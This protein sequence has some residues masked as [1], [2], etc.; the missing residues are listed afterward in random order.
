[1]IVCV[2]LPRFELAVAAGGLQSLVGRPVALAPDPSAP[3]GRA[4]IGEV[5]GAA[6]A[7]GLRPG[8]ALGEALTRCPE[9]ELVAGDPVGV[10]R[11]LGAGPPGT[12][13][14]RRS[15]RV[16]AAGTGLLRRPR[17]PRALRRIRGARDRGRPPGARHTRPP[18]RRAD[19]LLRAGRRTGDPAPPDDDH[20]RGR[21]RPSAQPPR[22][23]AP[24]P[25]N[26]RSPR[27]DARA[28]GDRHAR[29]AR[30]DAPSRADR[31]FRSG[32]RRGP[33]AGLRR[34]RPSDPP[35]AGRAAGRVARA[36]RVGFGSGARARPRRP[37]RPPARPSRATRP[38]AAGSHA[39]RPPG[40]CP[41]PR[42]AAAAA[43][44]CRSPS[45]S[46]RPTPSG[47]AWP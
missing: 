20:P 16:P 10:E 7:L 43:G 36:P 38:D 13:G 14:D 35:P 41:R 5:S 22:L 28:A 4:G 9:L 44:R 37:D 11:R 21:P 42:Q 6:Q 29:R 39:D 27:A 31:P 33:Q 19:P 17:P 23:D 30:R 24:L 46:R 34:G 45:A 47:C 2:L 25:A 1:M 40:R 12:R 15:G 32:R 26:D 8:M 3:A 18:G